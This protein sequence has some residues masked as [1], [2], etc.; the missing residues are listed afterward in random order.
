MHPWEGAPE[1]RVLSYNAEKA[2]V[3]YFADT[4][5]EKAHFVNCDGQWVYE[6]TSAA[7]SSLGGSADHY[8]I[9]PYFKNYVP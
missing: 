7:W 9:W 8:F 2:V 6:K 1:L 4:G 5:G 3:Y